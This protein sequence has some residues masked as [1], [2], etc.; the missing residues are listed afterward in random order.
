MILIKELKEL[1]KEM[2]TN[3]SDGEMR[4][5]HS[6]Q[7]EKQLHNT[8]LTKSLWLSKL[9]V[10][11]LGSGNKRDGIETFLLTLEISLRPILQLSV[12]C[13]VI[14]FNNIIGIYIARTYWF[15][16][17]ITTIFIIKEIRYLNLF[18]KN[19]AGTKVIHG[20]LDSSLTFRN[21]FIFKKVHV[22]VLRGNKQAK[23][24]VT[25]KEN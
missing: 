9:R 6:A 8:G 11:I 25:C 23:Q 2:W 21:F 22:E 12:N 1:L 17:N 3:L 20:N 5:Y 10:Q 15:R 4:F 19:W 18:F 7:E 24:N 16:D 13:S 14:C